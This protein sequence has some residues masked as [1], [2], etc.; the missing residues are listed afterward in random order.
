MRDADQVV[1]VLAKAYD[2]LDEV[3]ALRSEEGAMQSHLKDSVHIGVPLEAAL[4]E[5]VRELLGEQ[6]FGKIEG[7]FVSQS[8]SGAHDNEKHVV[9]YAFKLFGDMLG[10]RLKFRQELPCH[11]VLT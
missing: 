4:F 10:L 6:V 9:G 3:V 1:S 2:G 5:A 8:K 7:F 11:F